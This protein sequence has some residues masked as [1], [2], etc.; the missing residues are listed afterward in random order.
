MPFEMVSG[1]VLGMGVLDL[2]VIVE[3]AVKGGN[4]Q[5][6]IVTNEEFVESLCGSA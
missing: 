6:P 5:H 1:V 2:M 4:L 3:G